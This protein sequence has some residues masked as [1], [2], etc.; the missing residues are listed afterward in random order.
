MP[1][2]T[3][4]DHRGSLEWIVREFPKA[5]RISA[6]DVYW[7]D[8]SGSG[9]CRAPKSWK[10][11]YRQTDAWKEVPSPS[12]YGVSPNRYNHVAFSPVETTALRLEAQ[13]QP[14]FSSG[15]LE[16]KILP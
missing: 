5:R 13:L 4:W 7:F 2:F 1:R 16:W 12:D 10:L 14:Q 11:F 15:I 3:W 6:V 8:D 9:S